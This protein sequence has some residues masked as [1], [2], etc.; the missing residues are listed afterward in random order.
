MRSVG[1]DSREAPGFESTADPPP[2]SSIVDAG[3]LLMMMGGNLLDPGMVSVLVRYAYDGE[4]GFRAKQRSPYTYR[5]RGSAHRNLVAEEGAAAS[6]C[7][8]RMHSHFYLK[9]TDMAA[10]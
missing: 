1:S 7:M 9:K 8:K 2:L 6:G 5:P 3:G 4:D 10:G